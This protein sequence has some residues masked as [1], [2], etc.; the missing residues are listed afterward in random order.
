MIGVHD[1]VRRLNRRFKALNKVTLPDL[2]QSLTELSALAVQDATD[3]MLADSVP[4][5]V[6]RDLLDNY[7][8]EL[9]AWRGSTIRAFERMLEHPDAQTVTLQ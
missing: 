6:M 5:D 7:Y 1:L 2:R 4:P 8:T 3:Q 9:E